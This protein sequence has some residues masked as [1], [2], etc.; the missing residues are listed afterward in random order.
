M[1]YIGPC[2]VI[3]IYIYIYIC[4]SIIL[5]SWTRVSSNGPLTRYVKLRVA[6]APG[7]PGTFSTPLPVS[8]SDMQHDT[9]VTHVP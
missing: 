6:Y 1:E 5:C 3:Y 7:M 2:Y 4:I 8:D 9:C